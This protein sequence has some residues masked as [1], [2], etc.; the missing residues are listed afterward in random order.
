MIFILFFINIVSGIF[1]TKIINTPIFEGNLLNYHHIVLLQKKEFINNQTKYDDIYAI[2]FCPIGNLFEIISGKK[3]KGKIRMLYIKE[4]NIKD[5]YN[6]H[7]ILN[8]NNNLEILS[9][10]KNID[11]KIY[12]KINNW[13]LFFQL[14]N[15]NCRHFSNYLLNNSN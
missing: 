1:Y 4:S 15:R 14:Y 11:I 7:N 2:D 10:I 3:I 12:N 6:I 5:I 13:D 8:T 9:K